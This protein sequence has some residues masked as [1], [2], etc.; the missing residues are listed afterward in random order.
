MTALFKIENIFFYLFTMNTPLDNY[1]DKLMID[2]FP[3]K[4]IPYFIS[5]DIFIP[6]VRHEIKRVILRGHSEIRFGFVLD[7]CVLIPFY[8][9]CINNINI[10]CDNNMEYN[11][12]QD[13][14]EYLDNTNKK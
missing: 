1:I 2:L 8:A 4:N 6:W 9:N 12:P 13:V 3:E 11:L 5:L 14:I 7:R 10:D